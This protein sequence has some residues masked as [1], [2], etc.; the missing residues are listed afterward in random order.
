MKASACGGDLRSPLSLGGEITGIDARKCESQANSARADWEAILDAY[1]VDYLLL[2]AGYHS[3]LLPHV[4][5]SA[6]W[7]PAGG[8]GRALLFA[9]RGDRVAVTDIHDAR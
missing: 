1:G 2:D 8:A 3:E 5:A 7:E 9:R 6:R 4:R